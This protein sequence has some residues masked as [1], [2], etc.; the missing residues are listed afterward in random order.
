M[1]ILE[2][3]EEVRHRLLKVVSVV[4]GITFLSFW[5]ADWILEW[6]LK[7]APLMSQTLSSL[8]PAG[9]FT[10]SLRLSL[11]SG[12]ILA[13][14]LVLFQLWSFVSPGLKFRE[15]KVFLISLYAGTGLFFAGVLF[16]YYWVVPKT[17]LFFWDYSERL[18]VKPAWSIDYYLSFILM[19][20]ISFGI[21]F[22]LPLVILLL[23][24][25]GIVKRD[26]LVSKR[27]H[28]I[29]AI[30]ILAA[31]LTP[32]DV[33]SLLILGIPLWILFEISLWVSK[34]FGH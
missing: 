32:P 15:R 24:R 16:S 31:V 22:E 9:V 30:A 17:L 19:F 5:G 7:P 29:V 25:F 28:A 26:W 34:W 27:P 13:L 21:A 11:M 6:L 8:Q 4:F 20:L 1:P 12:V 33:I 23:I 10:Q 2:H 18:G 14:P 3:L